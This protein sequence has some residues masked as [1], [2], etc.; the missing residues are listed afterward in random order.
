MIDYNL[1]EECI[2]YIMKRGVDKCKYIFREDQT[3]KLKFTDEIKMLQTNIDK[4]IKLTVIKNYKK[5]SII[6]NKTDRSSIKQSIDALIDC[7]NISE[8]DENNDISEYQFVENFYSGEEEFDINDMYKKVERLLYD[9]KTFFP[10]IIISSGYINF[11][12]TTMRFIN[13]NGVDFNTIKRIYE[14]KIN[15]FA[16][17]CNN[18]SSLSEIHFKFSKLPVSLFEYGNIK[19]KLKASVDQLEYKVIEGK[20]NGDLIISPQCLLEFVKIYNY[21]FLREHSLIC[22]KSILQGKLNEKIASEKLSIS[23]SPVDSRICDKCFITDDGIK[24]KNLMYIDKGVLKSYLLNIYGGK[25]TGYGFT[26]STEIIIVENGESHLQDMIKSTRRG[27]ILNNFSSIEPE[28]NGDFSGVA[29]NSYYVENG[30]VK[31]P[32]IGAKIIGNLYKMFNN[33]ESISKYILNMG[34]A[35]IPYVK[36]NNVSICGDLK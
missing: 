15:Y 30:E 28:I 29:K 4:K 27:I 10:K 14:L 31:Y 21:I 13:S 17:E 7:C 9:I 26:P 36:V 18:S 6:I 24:T 19:E 23:C 5:S 16:K 3:T 2:R 35:I 12:V 11:N 25:K 33:I 32:I 1:G 8:E 22:G 20:F 34:F